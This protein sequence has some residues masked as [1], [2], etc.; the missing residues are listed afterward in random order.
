MEL[1]DNLLRTKKKLHQDVYDL[2]AEIKEKEK[3][4]HNMECLVYKNCNHNW[5]INSI[6]YDPCGPTKYH[7]TKCRLHKDEFMYQKTT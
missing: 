5:D 7:C 1:I 4:I 6:D 3:Q 2:R